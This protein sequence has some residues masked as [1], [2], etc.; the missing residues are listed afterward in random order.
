M[1]GKRKV[2]EDKTFLRDIW[3]AREKIILIKLSLKTYGR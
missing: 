3:K 2:N 1:E